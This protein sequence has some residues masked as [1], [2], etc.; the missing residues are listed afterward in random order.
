MDDYMNALVIANGDIKNY[1]ILKSVIKDVDFILCVDG[2]VDHIL[3]IN[4]KP[5]MVFG[6]LDSISEEGLS[7][8]KKENIAIE[9]F[10]SI[11]DSTDTELGI[12]YL[13]SQGYK[14]IT[15][16]GVTGSRQDHTLANIF[17]LDYL[18]EKNIKGKIVDNNNIIYLSD[19]YLKLKKTK[20]YYLSIIPIDL[21]GVRISLDGFFYNLQ[22]KYIPF[23]STLGVS[24]EI[25]EDYGE[26][27]IEEGK[28]LIF[29]SKD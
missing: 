18:L 22:S 23:G 16:M 3:K 24:N 21:A 6:D 9:R 17:L 20:G 26:I 28:A 5:H 19:N 29:Q 12:D 27:K 1:D 7:F 10:P 14:E 4:H 13:V 25:I 11:K 15:L 8:I 2:G